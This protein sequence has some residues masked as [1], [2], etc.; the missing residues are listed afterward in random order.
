MAK[1]GCTRDWA[2]IVILSIFFV[3][4]NKQSS[5]QNIGNHFSYSLFGSSIKMIGGDIDRS[6]I[7]QWAG[8]GLCYRYSTLI[9]FNFNS[10]YGWVRGRDPQGSQFQSVSGLKTT[11][12]PLNLSMNYYLNPD[13][14]IRPFL[15]FGSG[16]TLWR[17]EKISAGVSIF[18]SGKKI[19]GNR[20]NATII[21]GMGAEYC[22]WQNLGI[23][24]GFYY[25]R[26]FNQN[27]D[28]IGLGD[29]ANSGIVELRCGVSYF[30]T[31]FHDKDN[32]GMDDKFDLDPKHAE[33]FDGFQDDDGV[34][35]ADND[36]DGIPDQFDKSPNEAE[37]IDG[38]CDDD[39]I[40]DSDNDNDGVPDTIDRCPN[41]AE[42][43]DGF[44]D[45]DGCPEADNDSDG[46]T[47]S[48]DLCPDWP[49][50]FNDYLDNDGCPDE[51][52]ASTL[53]KVGEQIVTNQIR[54]S[55]DGELFSDRAYPILEFIYNLLN[56]YKDVKIEICY[57]L[58]QQDETISKIAD[59]QKLTAAI[60]RYLIELGIN[61]Q[62]IIIN[63]GDNFQ[64]GSLKEKQPT[65]PVIAFIRIQ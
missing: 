65:S 16:L 53:L 64:K 20:A 18:E 49:E 60:K 11:L 22:V 14:K 43:I 1:Q 62:R 59:S 46:I 28:T 31:I 36:L 26:L 61:Q 10:A 38:F 55:Q 42:D 8:L 57:Y 33:D 9:K 32:D 3:L 45:S 4:L 50:D 24:I 17:I 19:S 15:N 29:D 35:E 13:S 48:L 54:L 23:N 40:P 39:S 7:D 12:L 47:D 52:Q 56:D 58:F 34:P 2:S 44:E 30:F 27:K 63:R 5:A 21:C 51:K 41:T 6:T 37:D 25:H